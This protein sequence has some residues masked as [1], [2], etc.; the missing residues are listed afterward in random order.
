MPG[1]PTSWGL[2]DYLADRFGILGTPAQCI[3]K[4]EQIAEAGVSNIVMTA[5]AHDSLA[6]LRRLGEEV[7]AHFK[8]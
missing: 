3:A 6:A 2:T 1:C 7:V 8:K 5:F 4:V